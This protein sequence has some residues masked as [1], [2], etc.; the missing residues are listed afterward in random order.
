VTDCEETTERRG[1]VYRSSGVKGKRGRPI[2][3]EI[4]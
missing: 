1:G 3:R 2:E 4:K